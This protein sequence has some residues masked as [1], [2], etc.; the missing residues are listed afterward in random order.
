LHDSSGY[1]H[2]TPE[3]SAAGSPEAPVR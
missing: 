1:E 3:P 2:V